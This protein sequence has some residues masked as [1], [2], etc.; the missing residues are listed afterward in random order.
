VEVKAAKSAIRQ[1]LD[2]TAELQ[3]WKTKDGIEHPVRVWRAP[4]ERA[5]VLYFHGIE[6]HGRWFEDTAL[7]LNK[8]GVTVFA[9]D[10]R[11]AGSSKA[12]RGHAASW[13]Q[14][15]DDADEVLARVRHE[16]PET[17]IFI[18]ANCWGSKVALAL[19]GRPRNSFIRGLAMTSPAVCVQVDV[20][21]TTK[22]MIGL[23]LL[24]GG[25]HYFDIPLTAEHFTDIPKY[26]D[27]IRRDPLRLTRATASFFFESIKLTRQCKTSANGLT[28]PILI[29]QSGRDRIVNVEEIEQWFSKLSTPDK[30]LRIFT[31]AAHSLDFD[32]HAAD[33][34][35]ALASWILARTKQ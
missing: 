31:E 19:A 2:E 20:S 17:P 27:Y 8:K 30:T 35:D 12:L 15:V 18:V 4:A 16:N 14:L 22:L 6:S 7:E 3:W 28:M 26:L 1:D 33:Y 32:T 5:A 9:P 23:S 34:Q 13:R 25:K 21:L 10:R 11:G 24:T 29:L